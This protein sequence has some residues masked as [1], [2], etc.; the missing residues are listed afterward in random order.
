MLHLH[1]NPQQFHTVRYIYANNKKRERIVAFRGQQRSREH[2][3]QCSTHCI[4]FFR[5]QQHT[6]EG[7]AANR[8]VGVTVTQI[9]ADNLVL[10]EDKDWK[11]D[12]DK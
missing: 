4:V 11:R 10:A 9:A 8:R 1:S 2:A 6:A 3:T 7:K 12:G 5:N